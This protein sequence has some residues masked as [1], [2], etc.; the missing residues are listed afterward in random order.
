MTNESQA[1]SADPCHASQMMQHDLQQ[2]DVSHRYKQEIPK[3]L[4]SLLLINHFTFNESSTLKNQ[5]KYQTVITHYASVI[6]VIAEEW[7]ERSKLHPS[8]AKLFCCVVL[9]ATNI[10]TNQGNSIQLVLQY[11]CQSL[12]T[13]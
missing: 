1:V 4:N 7:I 10:S 13:H 8:N 5:F 12:K 2:T 11:C 6:I 9:E 3:Q